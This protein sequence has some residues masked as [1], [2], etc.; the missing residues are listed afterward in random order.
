MFI[1]TALADG[2]KSVLKNDSSLSEYFMSQF[3]SQI[4]R[5]HV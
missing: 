2:V 4:G 1:S 5:A 3:E